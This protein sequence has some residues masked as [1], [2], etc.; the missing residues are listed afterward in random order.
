MFL[1][2]NLTDKGVFC[3][4]TAYLEST[5]CFVMGLYDK[6]MNV[7]RWDVI[8][9]IVNTLQE[10]STYDHYMSIAPFNYKRRALVAL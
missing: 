7:R 4:I 2:I 3:G 5:Q 1:T 6:F 9:I 8:V 10:I